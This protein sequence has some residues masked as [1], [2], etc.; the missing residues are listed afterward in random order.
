MEYHIKTRS[1][2]SL[3]FLYGLQCYNSLSDNLKSA[4]DRFYFDNY[5]TRNKAF[6]NE[7]SNQIKQDKVTELKLLTLF[8][9]WNADEIQSL[10]RPLTITNY[11]SEN[12]PIARIEHTTNQISRKVTRLVQ[13][14]I[15]PIDYSKIQTF[16]PSKSRPRRRKQKDAAKI[17]PKEKKVRSEESQSETNT[18]VHH[19]ENL[20][21]VES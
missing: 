6:L 11:D 18:L 12:E 7:M 21:I 19:D 5:S 10:I 2:L 3:K 20:K 16:P 9:S 15:P 13:K 8:S 1:H 4:S 14:I 17:F